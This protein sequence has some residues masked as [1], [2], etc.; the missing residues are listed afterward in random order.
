MPPSLAT[1]PFIA[2]LWSPLFYCK[3]TNTHPPEKRESPHNVQAFFY[4]TFIVLFMKAF[5]S[6][7]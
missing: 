4:N 3:A 2:K 1:F 5:A 7:Y 6:Q